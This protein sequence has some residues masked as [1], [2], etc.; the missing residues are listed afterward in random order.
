[1]EPRATLRNRSINRQY[2]A[3]KC[4]QNLLVQPSSQLHPLHRVA[5]FAFGEAAIAPMLI[6]AA[7]GAS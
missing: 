1:M 7:Q 4:Q 5:A 6:P 3:R 2:A